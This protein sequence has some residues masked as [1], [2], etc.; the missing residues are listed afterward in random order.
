MESSWEADR[1]EETVWQA[2]DLHEQVKYLEIKYR[3]DRSE[4][5]VLRTSM[6]S[7]LVS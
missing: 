7:M 5:W 4:K 6:G 1:N 2:L 3:L